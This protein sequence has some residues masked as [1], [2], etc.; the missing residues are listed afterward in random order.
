MALLI[1]LFTGSLHAAQ[2]VID[3]KGLIH[4]GP[5]LLC[6]DEEAMFHL[7]YQG[8]PLIHDI[9]VYSGINGYMDPRALQNKEL[10]RQADRVTVKGDITQE[11]ISL[12]LTVSVDGN[13]LRFDIKRRGNW[14]SET[15]GGVW[16]RLPTPR[17]AG[18]Q[19]K[20]GNDTFTYPAEYQPGP[21]FPYGHRRMECHLTDPALNF[22]LEDSEGVSVQ[23]QRQYNGAHFVMSTSLPTDGASGTSTFYLTLPDVEGSCQPP[24]VRWS[25]I[26]YPLKGEKFVMLEWS[27]Y[28][29][30]PD[31]RAHLEDRQGTTVK[32]GRFGP[33]LNTDDI[34]GD[35]AAFDFTEVNVP[36]QYRVVW[37]GGATGWFPIAEQV[38][39][40]ELWHKALD[41]F[42]P[43]EMCH[44]DVNLGPD[45]F[46]HPRCHRDDAARVS[47]DH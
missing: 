22:I 10:I 47:A 27:D 18:A 20:L 35:Y 38:F 17:Y 16:F 23:D 25:H 3:N 44:V 39:V 36:G 40:D 45:V 28:D 37:S 5:Y 26:G 33:T 8:R 30:R 1:L 46:G 29:P 32:A 4:Q 12:E 42:I 21:G 34:Q 2:P 9:G 19:F 41:Y 43:F 13:R 24:A 11:G 14:P 6:G 31:D 7:L 15:W